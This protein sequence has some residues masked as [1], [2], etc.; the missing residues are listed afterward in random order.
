MRLLRL[1]LLAAGPSQGAGAV[2]GPGSP[3][4]DHADWRTL[5]QWL[6]A[7]G[8]KASEGLERHDRRLGKD[9]PT[10]VRSELA[11][12]LWNAIENLPEYFPDTSPYLVPGHDSDG[13]GIPDLDDSLPFDRDNDN[14]PDRIDPV[15]EDQRSVSPPTR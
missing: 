7:L 15:R 9:S 13:D 11:L 1:I 3:Q 14:L 2:S 6:R 4:P 10:L 12:H 5:S 8:W